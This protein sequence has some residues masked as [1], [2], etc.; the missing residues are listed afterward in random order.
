MR[1]NLRS[2]LPLAMV[3]GRGLLALQIAQVQPRASQPSRVT[4]NRPVAVLCALLL[5]AAW[6]I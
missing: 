1:S 2:P 4:N 6:L 5:A 3:G